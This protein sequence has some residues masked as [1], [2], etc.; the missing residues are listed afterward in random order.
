MDPGGKTTLTR[1]RCCEMSVVAVTAPEI[2]P[3]YGQ[4]V[5]RQ[6]TASRQV[7]TKGRI[8][9]KLLYSSEGNT[10]DYVFKLF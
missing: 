3:I 9:G 7:W 8:T 6:D 1:I 2:S 4:Y 5:K 10:F